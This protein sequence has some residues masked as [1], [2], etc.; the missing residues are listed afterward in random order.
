M[1]IMPGIAVV[2]AV[3]LGCATKKP[4]MTATPAD[5]R[6]AAIDSLSD[7]GQY[8]TALQATEA[9]RRQARADGDPHTEFRAWM[10]TAHFQQL[11]GVDRRATIAALEE[12]AA[13]DEVPLGQLLRSVIAEQY[14]QWYQQD[15]WRVL[16][17][18]PM[19]ETGDDPDTWDQA[20]FMRKV[21]GELLASLEPYDTLRHMP[22]G[23]LAPLLLPKE[24]ERLN[25][26]IALRPTVHD[27]LAHRAIAIF[28]NT[29][30]R[31]SEPAWRFTLD[32]PFFF[33]L[34]E[35]FA[36]RTLTHRDSTAWEFQ[37]LRLYQ[38]LELNHLSGSEPDALVDVTLDRLQYVHARSTLPNKDS[39]HLAAL[40][41]LRSRLPQNSCEA[42]VMTAIAR[43]HA[44]QGDKYD[45][46]DTAGTWKW[47]RKAAVDMARA[48][49]AKWPGSFGAQN[50][51]ALV[52]RLETPAISIR[53]EQAQAPET[54]FRAAL[55]YTNVKQV[56]LRVVKDDAVN[57][58]RSRRDEEAYRRLLEL[59]PV[60]AWSATLPDDGD[61]N[62]H[63]VELP[64]DGLPTGSYQL[65]VSDAESFPPGQANVQFTPFTVTRLALA[66]RQPPD[67][68][69]AV[70]VTDRTTGAPVRDAKAE[71]ST[72]RWQN[73]EYRDLLIG[74]TTTDADGMATIKLDESV[75]G[76][77]R[78]TITH[79]GEK[80]QAQGYGRYHD[81]GPD[82][83]TVR[84]FLFTDRAIYR[85]GQE[86]H[87]KGIVSVKRG[88]TTVVKA[89][90]RTT[91][92]FT[93]AN[94]EEIARQE[95]VT[96]DH[97][98]FHGT[99][100]APQ[101]VLTGAMAISDPHGSRH[102]RV[103]EY[104]R[105]TFE[106]VFDPVATAPKLGEQATVSGTAK[107]HAGV[108][109][110]G[111]EVRWKVMR[112]AR[113]PWWCGW[114]WRS[115]IPWG[116][117]TEIANG[118]GRTDA[119]GAFTVEFLAEADRSIAR[120]ADPTFVYTVEAHVTDMNGETQEGRTQLSVGHR[121]IDL[122]IGLGDAV[123]RSTVDSV[124]M[125]VRNLN[126]ERMGIPFDVRITRLMKPDG[127]PKRTRPWERPD[128][129]VMDAAEFAALFPHDAYGDEHDPAHWAHSG[130]SFGMGQGLPD[131]RPLDLSL[132]RGWDVGN[133]LIEMEARDPG[134]ELVKA[135]KVFTLYDPAV[136]HTGFE[137]AAF[138]VQPVRTTVGPGEKAVL[139][140]G[141]GLPKAHVLMEVERDGRI[142]VRRWFAIAEGQQRVELETLESD[143]GGYT[144][145]FICIE[146]GRE[147]RQSL[148]IDVPWSNKELHVEWMTFRDKL[149]PGAQ[150]EW[151]LRITGEKNSKVAAQVLAAM[152][153]ASLDHFVPH[154][155]DMA[156]W[157]RHY[158]RLGWGR[159]VPF[160]V[161][162][163][164]QP[165]WDR[166]LPGDTMHAY[167]ELD[168]YGLDRYGHRHYATSRAGGD[169][170]MLM[171]MN[172]A[173]PASGAMDPAMKADAEV[174]ESE[175][176]V[177]LP[178]QESG[179][180]PAPVPMPAIRTDFR[181]T[182][183]FFPD[184]LTDKDGAVILKFTMPEAL[185]RWKLLG[186]AHTTDLKVGT[187]TKE[188]IT[189]K[190]LMVVPNLPRFL[191]EGDRI[192]LTAKINAIEA[193]V[194]GSAKLELFDP[195]TGKAVNAAFDLKDNARG[196]TAAP[197][198][199]ANVAWDIT[200]PEGPPAGQ[201][202]MHMVSVRITASGNGSSDGEEKPLPVLSD[203]LLVTE[204]LPLWS[205]GKG[206][207]TFTLDKLKNNTSTTLRTQ[208]LKLEYTPDPAWYAVQAL[209]YLMEYPH[210]CAEQV[211]SRYFANTLAADIVEKRPKIKEVFA[212][213]KRSG[214]EA[215]AS[216][217]EKNTELKGI[218]LEETPWV[219]NAR[220]ERESKERIA[221]LFDLQRMGTEQA[222]AFKK[223]RGMQLPNGAWPWWSGMRESRYITQH[224][225]AGF[226]HLEK[227]GAADLRPDGMTQQ[228][229][230]SA[231]RWL[232][233][234]V[235]RNHRELLR[236]T[237]KEDLEQYV[238]G[239][240][241][242]HFLYTRSFF[243]RWAIDGATRTAVDF[244]VK[245]LQA[246]W[247][248]HGLQEQALAALALHRL[249]ETGTAQLI[250]KSLSER[251]TRD[252]ERGMY[253]K[254]FSRGFDWWAFPTETHA[255]LIEA[256]NDV[257]GDAASVHALRTYLLRLKQT[258]DWK[259]T[260][261][262]A[263]A[264][265]ALLLS[266]DDWLSDAEAPVITV[267]GTVVK[268]DKAE[269]G[270]GTFA[271]V[272]APESVKPAMGE[273]SITSTTDRPSWGALHWQYL[274]RMDKITPHESPFSIR[275][276][277]FLKRYTD[278]GTQL[279]ALGDDAKLR[280][281][282][283]L[284]I[285]IE[286]RTDRHVDYVHLKDLRGAGLE[287]VETLSGYRY[288][289]GL[290]YYRTT[291][292]ASVNFFFD[293]ITPGTYV[294]EYDLK[295]GHAGDFSNGIT[296]AMC[297]YAP[298]FSSH[299]EGTRIVVGR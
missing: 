99:F 244:Y 6:W 233:G 4:A 234:E 22:V 101:G 165:W 51:A 168:R 112:E 155:W 236:R 45:R 3:L 290:G 185:T 239:H 229:I 291:R 7:Q 81:H 187:F 30:T 39:L 149:L 192:T 203:K 140:I 166:G 184:L 55:A 157:P 105:P 232:D 102:I 258:T 201:A 79:G 160:G 223:L 83:D 89:G 104:K 33:T 269:A 211:F 15:R 131:E 279:V 250:M 145:H 120:A 221:L 271:H 182:A 150:E 259:T 113:M 204:S 177:G 253:W 208:G 277:V 41:L 134:G 86:V 67:D 119:A 26:A 286:L 63:L 261:A 127:G 97:G 188:T 152:Y 230:K 207:K 36:H 206:T 73:G 85:P 107:S 284:T 213:W 138:H 84:T 225:V 49:I 163:G 111:A 218:V 293:R 12:R 1:K 137:H 176:G 186:L 161:A 28:R 146:R 260:K 57:D 167:P 109:L 220:N 100:T 56:W 248:R 173:A 121:S 80:Q 108:P 263:E 196:F 11:T 48:A 268:A 193:S 179:G 8:A 13:T 202:G 292:D 159:A 70:L 235:E 77:Y 17:R 118:A 154:G 296:T 281:G 32:D 93:D 61:L 132:M 141:S 205:N 74:T 274:E 72:Q 117:P 282:D 294:L 224:I 190:P 52:A 171:E 123:D 20:A 210:D 158:A 130:S 198:Q 94:G 58:R 78:W 298:E 14:W 238:P 47:E 96:D 170:L 226:G 34:F 139:L 266:G 23:D 240:T 66:T 175:A 54:P 180:A 31:I 262:T 82:A 9:L 126:G 194:T 65:I 125:A 246:T 16:E 142:V 46:L 243:T 183:F 90:H 256:Y 115:I 252:E 174:E 124:E 27:L 270:T 251:A 265:Y 297:M 42:E 116:R 267:G 128:R 135:S 162:H 106:V 264:C 19:G 275:K 136:Q 43:W 10:Y 147:H 60:R 285:R 114:Y 164:Q 21:I 44:A 215:F 2:V 214:P 64:V 143:R 191:R 71:L 216:A 295:V 212:Q 231:V 219:L 254:G 148:F 299:S 189:Q 222:A 280:P 59:P 287:P 199:S 76:Q 88:G 5:P 92:R 242:I 133:Y 197:G 18:T 62:E 200:V 24:A 209:P 37:A 38:Q 25:A 217:L 276:Q 151:R 110:D 241:D 181:E 172:A 35:P 289:G 98:A 29:E 68:Q 69:A 103:E 255:L 122:H 273:V 249:G 272:F 53:T 245:R 227:L 75:R 288:Q 91:V 153:D 195:F 169:G 247:P 87:Y 156:V 278:A 95:A 144:V 178:P 50:A 237:K 40:E 228:M 257:T 283:R 129:T